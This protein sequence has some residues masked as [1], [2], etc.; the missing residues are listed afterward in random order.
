MPEIGTIDGVEA[1]AVSIPLRRPF[2]FATYELTHLRY[3]WLRIQTTSG[4]CGYGEAPTY[5]DPTGET[6]LAAIGAF[7]L[8]RRLLLG[9]PADDFRGVL[10]TTSGIAPG[11]LAARCALESALLDLN[12][13]AHGVPAFRLLGAGWHERPLRV[14]A[15][16]GLAEQRDVNSTVQVVH[17][18]VENGFTTLK[19]KI[20][21]KSLDRDVTMVKLL[22]EAF[23]QL[24][25]FADANQSWRSAKRALRDLE[26]LSDAGL[27]YVEQP[28][29]ARD[30]MGH[31]FVRERTPL[32]VILDESVLTVDDMIR[33]RDVGALDMVNIKL[34]KAGGPLS[35][36]AMADT[37]RVLNI[38]VVLGSMVESTLGMHANFHAAVRMEPAFCGMSVYSDVNDGSGSAISVDRAR[39]SLANPDR[40]G[41]GYEREQVQRVFESGTQVPDLS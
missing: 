14:N 11:A 6:Q 8:W 37:A 36:A 17:R 34:A 29:L 9:M 23:P 2:R 20:S 35:A 19:I 24:T 16:L 33:A 38:G 10:S 31:A 30:L 41:L 4:E 3:A 5:W 12:G 22:R 21:I 18:F 32:E 15:V 1:R 25:M 28:L 39:L 7:Q 26:R 13:H 27:D 40:P